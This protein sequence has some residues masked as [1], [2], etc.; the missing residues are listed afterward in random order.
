VCPGDSG[1]N[2]CYFGNKKYPI[3]KGSRHSRT[4]NFFSDADIN[5]LQKALL[6]ISDEIKAAALR[7][8]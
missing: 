3:K 2:N 6:T 4:K 1:E 7:L 8:S 5:K